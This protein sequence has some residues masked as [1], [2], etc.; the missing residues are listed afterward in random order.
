MSTA[1]G[2]EV[3]LLLVGA[4]PV[5]LYGAYYAGV[6]GL[7]VA[8]VDSLPEPGG[9]V[10]AMYP[11]KPIYDVGG[12]PR[13]LGRDL[14]AG[15]VEQAGQYD[16]TYLLG[17]EAQGL[18]PDPGAPGRFVVTTSAGTTVRT[19]TVVVTGGIGTFSPR[20]LPA[21]EDLLG[22]GLAY[23]VPSFADYAGADVVVVGGGDSACD[24]ALALLPVARS[25]TLVH[26]RKAFRAH[27]ATVEAVHASGA[28]V[29]VDA[30]VTALRAGPD[31]R[32]AAAE[33]TTRDGVL[34]LPAQRV[35][36][37]LGFVADLG[38]LRGWGL[39]LHDNRHVVVDTRMGT[40]VPGVYAAGDITDYPGKVR[41]ISVGF[42]EVAT[43]V[44]NAAVHLDPEVTLFP[45][46]SSDA[47]PAPVPV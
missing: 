35:V 6:R 39:D 40:N 3:D 15:L 10:T 9:Q 5:G 37:A 13:V 19:G 17:E 14:V 46:H 29:L 22:R 43:A 2:L 42:G 30:Q 7:R 24:W 47:A 44:N 16:P 4:G 41:L 11:E 33:V 27:A 32:V 18:A 38:P 21:G 31:G 34:T 20:P 23:F 45:G 28:T 12:F 36:A 1:R 26:R 8:V 25:V